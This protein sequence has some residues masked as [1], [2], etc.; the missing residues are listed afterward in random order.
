MDT[1]L[2]EEKLGLAPHVLHLTKCKTI[3]EEH[4]STLYLVRITWAWSTVSLRS[5]SRPEK[6]SGIWTAQNLFKF[7]GSLKLAGVVHTV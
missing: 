6:N 7:V 2:S 3:R 1:I 4:I 5:F